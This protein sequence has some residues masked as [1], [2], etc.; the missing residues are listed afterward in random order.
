MQD[1]KAYDIQPPC[2]CLLKNRIPHP[3]KDNR[4]AMIRMKNYQM[5][6][7]CQKQMSSALMTSLAI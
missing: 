4:Q 2:K 3:Q 7:N 1:E 6:T 5:P